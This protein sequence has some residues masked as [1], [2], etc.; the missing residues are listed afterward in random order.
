MLNI[1]IHVRELDRGFVLEWTTW[2]TGE[3]EPTDCV[4]EMACTDDKQLSTVLGNL[5]KFTDDVFEPENDVLL[6]L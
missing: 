6:A 4:W 1:K 5:G 2:D 3:D